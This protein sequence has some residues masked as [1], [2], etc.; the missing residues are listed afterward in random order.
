MIRRPPRST[1]FPYTTLF[2]SQEGFAYIALPFGVIFTTG[3]L[4]RRANGVAALTTIAAGFPFTLFLQLYLFGLPALAPYANSLHR[5]VIAW[6]FC[7]VVMI[8][9]SLLTP[10]PSPEKTNGIIWSLSYAPLPLA[11]QKRYHG[12]KDLRIWW[13]IFISIVLGIYAFLLW[14]R[15]QHPEAPCIRARSQRLRPTQR[16]PGPEF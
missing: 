12:W 13:L 10:A 3:L 5:A 16:A 1:L 4:W 7:M 11:E 8:T 6:A 2:R 15:F 14:F 9:T